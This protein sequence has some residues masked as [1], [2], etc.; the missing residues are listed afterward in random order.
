MCFPVLTRKMS[1][2]QS[3]AS[4]QDKLPSV[5]A[6]MQLEGLDWSRVN[7]LKT[8]CGTCRKYFN[9]KSELKAHTPCGKK[10]RINDSGSGHKCPE[11]NYRVS[12][13]FHLRLHLSFH[14]DER[15]WKCNHCSYTCHTRGDLFSHLRNIH[16]SSS[17]PIHRCTKRFASRVTLKQHSVKAHDCKLNECK[18]CGKLHSKSHVCKNK[19]VSSASRD[20]RSTAKSL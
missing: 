19:N 2:R 18:S 5:D 4:V 8:K 1:A 3:P 12:G 9:T 20:R 11:C 16:Y 15:T 14:Y 7:L 6:L 10:Y 13:I 17:C